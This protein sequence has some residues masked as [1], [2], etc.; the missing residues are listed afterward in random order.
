MNSRD[1]IANATNLAKKL[2]EQKLKVF[3]Y[4]KKVKIP[5]QMIYRPE[6]DLSQVLNPKEV[7]EYQQF[8]VIASRIIELGRV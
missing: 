8:V 5:M 6:I 7:Q 2:M 1:Y 4:G 3:V